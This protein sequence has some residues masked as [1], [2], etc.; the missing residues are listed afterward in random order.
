M[1]D[2]EA[3]KIIRTELRRRSGKAWSVTQSRRSSYIQVTS[4]PR[5]RVLKALSEA[6]RVELASLL[7]LD[8]V[9][10]FGVF[11]DH[12]ERAEYVERARGAY[13]G[14]K[15]GASHSVSSTAATSTSTST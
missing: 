6:D 2:A 4:P 9:A 1:N 13:E 12:C 11:I 8:R 7:G 15:T 3:V 5:R 10:T 14:S